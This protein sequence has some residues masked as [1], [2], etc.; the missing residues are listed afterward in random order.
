MIQHAGKK[1]HRLGITVLIGQVIELKI[2]DGNLLNEVR[3]D[4]GILRIHGLTKQ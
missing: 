4:H 3:E 2:G 1:F